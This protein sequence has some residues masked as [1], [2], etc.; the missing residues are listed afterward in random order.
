MSAV[1]NILMVQWAIPYTRARRMKL[2]VFKGN[3]GSRRVFEKN[4]FKFVSES[5]VAERQ[6]TEKGMQPHWFLEWK[7]EETK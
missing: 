6:V 5:I 3:I 1:I 2:N 4:G 7:Y